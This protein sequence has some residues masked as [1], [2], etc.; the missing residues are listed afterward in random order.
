MTVDGQTMED[1]TVT[2]RDR[3]SLEQVRVPIRALGD[4][5]ARRLTTPWRTPKLGS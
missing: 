4:D 3:D 5:L 1:D 2:L